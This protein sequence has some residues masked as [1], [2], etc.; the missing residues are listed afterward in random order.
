MM[1]E[2]AARKRV[3]A[4]A[5]NTHNIEITEHRDEL[6]ELKKT[7]WDKSLAEMRHKSEVALANSTK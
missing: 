6:K 3:V 7:E 2:L 1:N 4:N 5:D